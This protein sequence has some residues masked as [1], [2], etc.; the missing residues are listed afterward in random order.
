[1]GA[2]SA[3]QTR[4]KDKFAEFRAEV[5]RGQEYA[6]AW[7]LKRVRSATSR[8]QSRFARTAAACAHASPAY[9]SKLWLETFQQL[10]GVNTSA[11]GGAL[12]L[13]VWGDG[14]PA[15]ELSQDAYALALPPPTFARACA[16][17]GK[18]GWLARLGL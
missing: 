11:Q 14:P 16:Y 2:F 7:A 12:L 15:R 9:N 4:M 17:A 18:Y 1:M 13:R 10:G 6:A 8:N 3:F 5:R